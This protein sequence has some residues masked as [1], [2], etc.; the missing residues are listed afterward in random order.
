M[1]IL[2]S[3]CLLGINCRYSGD[4]K[5]CE[6]ITALKDKYNIIPI[7]PE[8]LGGLSTPRLPAEIKNDR[9]INK[10][11]KDVTDSFAKGAQI[12]VEIAKLFGCK[13]A[14]LKKNSPSCGFGNI[15]DGSFCG[16]LIDGNGLTADALSKAG[17]TILNEDNF[18]S[19]LK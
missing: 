16:K 1:Y 11:G 9:V 4:S 12:T 2:V 17:L 19:M 8:Q 6:D 3:S 18:G 7:C 5:L 14:I 10:N 15:Y 13:Y